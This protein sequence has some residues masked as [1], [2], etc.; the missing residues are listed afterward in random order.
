MREDDVGLETTNGAVQEQ[1]PAYLAKR[2]LREETENIVR[3][4]FGADVLEI[5]VFR[6]Q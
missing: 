4:Q 5:V 6:H 2:A 3:A 1:Q